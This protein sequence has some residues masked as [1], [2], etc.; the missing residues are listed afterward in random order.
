MKKK[1]LVAD[2][3]ITIQKVVE[4]TFPPERYEVL[5]ASTG[6]QAIERFDAERPDLAL[7]DAVM[8]DRTGYDVCA[9]VKGNEDTAWVP[10]VLLSGTFE[11]FDEAKAR[12]A[13]ADSHMRKPFESR[14]L[15]QTVEELLRSHPRPGAE[16]EPEPPAAPE[17]AAPAPPSPGRPAQ[18]VKPSELFDR[19]PAGPASKPSPES[20]RP[21]P[22]IADRATTVPPETLERAVK[23]A[24]AG[25]SEK[26]VREVAWEVIPDLAEAIIKRRIQELEQE[27]EQAESE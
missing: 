15:I 11:P 25:I 21:A 7:L 10:V 14:S 2:D 16:A 20:A 24:V 26:I 18:G 13:G 8:P 1:I 22:P 6:S 3:S 12:Q 17:P 27:A 19:V 5:C 4:L 23:D 9:H